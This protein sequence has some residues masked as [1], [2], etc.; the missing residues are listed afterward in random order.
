MQTNRIAPLILSSVDATTIAID[1]WT[2]FSVGGAPAGGIIAPIFMLRI[3]N[4][5]NSNVFI[6]FNG[7]DRHIC[8]LDWKNVTLYFQTN[9][10]PT[11]NVSKI[12]TG[13][14]F[15]VQGETDQQGGDI[16]ITGYYNEQY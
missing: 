9:N 10:T 3:T 4:R 2:T 14:T 6:S 11:G 16:Y 12:M 8:V 15:Y 1:T 5:C 7:V 13:T